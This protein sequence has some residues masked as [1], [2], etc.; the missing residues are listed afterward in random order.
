MFDQEAV[1]RHVYAALNVS[2]VTTLATGGIFQEIAPQ[3]ANYP[4]VLVRSAGTLEEWAS[5]DTRMMGL[6]DVV[7]VGV[8]EALA[9]NYTLSEKIDDALKDASSV[10]GSG[11]SVFP[12]YSKRFRPF[13]QA[14]EIDGR[15]YRE[16][17]GVY[18]VW[19]ASPLV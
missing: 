11:A 1:D 6:F 13:K 9:Y 12:V 15:Q 14:Y 16:M 18:R 3:G 5:Q 10:Q 8:V 7:V 2:A 4:L 19:A 17:G